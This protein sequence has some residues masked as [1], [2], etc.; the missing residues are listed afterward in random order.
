M[1]WGILGG[2]LGVGLWGLLDLLL[3]TG[4]EAA[5]RSLR[6]ARRRGRPA[7]RA[8]LPGRPAGDRPEEAGSPLA[9]PLLGGLIGLGAGGLLLALGGGGIWPFVLP[10]MGGAGGA[11]AAAVRR[12]QE[13]FRRTAAEIRILE[14]IALGMAAAGSLEAALRRAAERRAAGD[15]IEGRLRARLGE[16]LDEALRR[17]GDGLAALEAWART[18]DPAGLGPVA[19]AVRA[20]VAAGGRAEETLLRA[21]D[22]A[23]AER[24]AELA[25]RLRALPDAALPV[26]GLG[27]FAP[28]L[29]LLMVPLAAR[30]LALLTAASGTAFRPPTP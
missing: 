28:I 6:R 1:V 10:A 9:L 27:M 24:T 14:E 29:G 17:G 2:I 21:A 25:A 22:E 3:R 8:V 19:A 26:V 30:L 20:A 4:G 23:A 18:A 12:W 5:A 7:W 16:A 11:L 13:G 15:P